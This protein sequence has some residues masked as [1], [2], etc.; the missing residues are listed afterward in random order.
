[1]AGWYRR[2][3]RRSG[4][5][6]PGRIRRVTLIAVPIPIADPGEIDRAVARAV[7]AAERGADLIEWRIDPLAGASADAVPEI[8]AVV[9]TLIARSPRPSIVT[10]RSVDEGGMF[11][12]PDGAHAAALLVGIGAL[13]PPPAYLDLEFAL[14]E[15][16]RARLAPLLRS[17]ADDRA[18]VILSCHDFSGR[19]PD[20]T[21]RVRRL[22]DDPC[23]PAVIKIA[24]RAR[25]VRDNLE[26]FDLLDTRARPMI[27]LCMGDAGLPSRVL[28]PRF[29][30]FLT[31]AAPE[32]DEATAPGQPTIDE[33]TDRYRVRAIGASTALYGVIGWPVAQSPGPRVHNRA[34]AQSGQDAVYLPLP[35][36]PGWE[37]FKASLA[38]LLDHG[39]PPGRGRIGLRGASVTIPHKAHLLRFAGA[40]GGRLSPLA[41]RCGVANTLTVDEDGRLAVDNTDAPAALACLSAALGP[42][43]TPAGLR[44]A[45]LGAGGA[46]RAIAAVL[47]D[48][49]AEVRVVAR[50]PAQARE[51]AESIAASGAAASPGRAP[52]CTPGGDIRAAEPD[53]LRAAEIDVVVNATPVGMMHGPSPDGVP[54]PPGFTLS[55]HH[56]VFETVASPENTALVRAARAA[57]A[58]VVT[59]IDL[60]LAQA[61]LQ[62]MA[63][64]GSA[65]PP[66]VYDRRS[67]LDEPIPPPAATPDTPG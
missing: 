55:P 38:D 26:A 17:P 31:F 16:Q 20:L 23:D 7:R 15:R 63:W 36:A 56:L 52:P 46:A 40:R 60:F 61:L 41:Q 25:S 45:I 10:L 62:F 24:W 29:G 33:M 66:D 54:L 50:R 44:V 53:A 32:R 30:A 22:I 47:V 65:P 18:R 27:A 2:I 1:M 11:D 9:R 35:V 21:A 42:G 37:S 57:G 6:R 43:R 5:A 13:Q 19:P 4:G 34:F 64:T 58:R 28:A 49:G 48:G 8:V 51:L 3:H 67:L 39:G 12:D 59:G 14:L